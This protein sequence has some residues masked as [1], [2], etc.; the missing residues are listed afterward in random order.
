MK[1]IVSI[2]LESP[3]YLTIPLRERAQLIK[4][5]FDTWAGQPFCKATDK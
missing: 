3:F 5:M 2:L 4:R 1:E